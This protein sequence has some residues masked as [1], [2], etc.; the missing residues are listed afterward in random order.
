MPYCS[1][2]GVE[3]NQSSSS[4]PLC[5]TQILENTTPATDA[6]FPANVPAFRAPTKKWTRS[7]TAF[8]VAT[9]F[10]I[11]IFLVISADLINNASIEWSLLVV[12]PL[13]MALST[14]LVIIY[15]F[16]K[17]IILTL[18]TFVNL[19]AFLVTIGIAIPQGNRYFLPLALSIA[20]MVFLLFLLFILYC[21][22]TKIKGF[23]LIGGF[24]VIAG[25]IPF[26]ID[27]FIKATFYNR[28]GI[29]PTW[30][31]F[32]LS[33]CLPIAAFFFYLHY[34]RKYY[35]SFKRLFHL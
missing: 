30:S 14:S 21:G 32:P 31:L 35:P 8:L 28:D 22:F 15:F 33:A 12:A 20:S 26:F 25:F 24:F 3:V 6:S 5:D 19:I 9:I 17:P 2:C 10:L 11:P 34:I 29:I 7:T 16:K 13:V 1:R 4:C 27:I 18:F 23:N